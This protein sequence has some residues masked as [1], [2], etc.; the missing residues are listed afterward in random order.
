MIGGDISDHELGTAY[1]DQG[2]T[3]TDTSG[4]YNLV[5]TGN[6]DVSIVGSNT[7]TYTATD[8]SGNTSVKTKKRNVTVVDTTAPEITITGSHDITHE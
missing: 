3:I 8:A 4:V 5:T 7:I 1:V 2:A 6:V